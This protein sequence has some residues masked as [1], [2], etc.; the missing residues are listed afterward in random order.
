M[1]R[2][3]LGT[4]KLN[5]AQAVRMQLLCRMQGLLRFVL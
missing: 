5:N 1:V 4:R 3:T 2:E